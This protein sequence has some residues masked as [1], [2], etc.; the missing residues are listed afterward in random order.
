ME[1]QKVGIVVLF[2][3]FNTLVEVS[4]MSLKV[5]PGS[6]SAVIQKVIDEASTVKHATVLFAQGE[7][8]L[9]APIHIN[10]GITLKGQ[11]KETRL[12]IKKIMPAE[13][14]GLK[15]HPEEDTTSRAAILIEEV[16][17]I[18][19]V[20]IEDLSIVGVLAYETDDQVLRKPGDKL[21]RIG[22]TAI[23]IRNSSGVCVSRCYF[24]RI[25]AGIECDAS[26]QC[27]FEELD[28][29]S[30]H[31][32]I[33]LSCGKDN[34][35]KGQHIIRNNQFI[36]FGQNAISVWKQDE[37]WISA[38]YCQGRDKRTGGAI[39]LTS[40]NETI[41]KDNIINFT[42]NGIQFVTQGGKTCNRNIVEENVIYN[43]HP[44]SPSGSGL[45]LQADFEGIFRD[46]I[47]RRNTVSDC[48]VGVS[49]SQPNPDYK[50]PADNTLIEHNVISDCLEWGILISGNS[51][52]TVRKNS[53]VNTKFIGLEIRQAPGNVPSLNNTISSNFLY[54]NAIC[55]ILVGPGN[56]KNIIV[57]NVLKNNFKGEIRVKQ[58]SN[59]I[60]RGNI[61]HETMN[62]N[63]NWNN[64][65]DGLGIDGGVGN[66]VENNRYYWQRDGQ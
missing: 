5:A 18:P 8:I 32:G 28:M 63:R 33:G 3:F 46:N 40:C 37:C 53:I 1:L 45:S 50:G 57:D 26:Q 27:T 19:S 29:R 65:Q 42:E 51:N 48:C 43:V 23:L 34:I 41:I 10:K 39:F 60:V 56:D 2:L 13:N 20:T 44:F 35:Y 54:N 58:S 21:A 59:N 17:T 25:C 38:N 12:I 30:I 14:T 62:Y 22:S 15:I 64:S 66:I 36:P 4:A 9:D 49:V 24:D 11:G 47:F 31:H 55:G 16:K 7:Y 61:I 52:T 6:D